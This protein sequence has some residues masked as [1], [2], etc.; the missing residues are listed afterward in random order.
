MIC[1]LFDIQRASMV[2][3]PGIRTTFFFKGC[4]LRCA[5]CHNPESQRYQEELLVYPEKCTGCGACKR[6]CPHPEGPCIGCGACAEV[7]PTGARR[8]AG[9][10]Y[11]TGELLKIALKDKEYYVCSG[12]GVT[13]SGGEAMLYPDAIAE[14][15]EKCK[16]EDISTAVDTAGFVP[17]ESFEKVRPFTDLFLY[18]IKSMEPDI[19]KRYTGVGN[20]QTLENYKHLISLGSRVWV[21]FPVIPGVNDGEENLSL[22]QKLFRDYPPEKVEC[23]PYHKMGEGKYTALGRECTCFAPPSGEEIQKIKA[24]LWH[25]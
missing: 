25:D 20:E 11:T 15:A 7:C 3:G 2:D 19:H 17:W 14:L 6:A 10:D 12:G 8:L 13:F 21:R 5:W 24:I 18:D 22:M 4:N 23:L 1:R 16:K 9:K